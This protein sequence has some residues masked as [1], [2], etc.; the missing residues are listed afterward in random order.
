MTTYAA[1]SEGPSNFNITKY[2]WEIKGPFP[3]YCSAA[4]APASILKVVACSCK[5]QTSCA[6]IPLNSHVFCT[7]N[8]KEIV[9]MKIKKEKMEEYDE[10][11]DE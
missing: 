7:A 5:S 10:A 2:G 8:T 1:D 4:V 9:T 11:D 6:A 3:T